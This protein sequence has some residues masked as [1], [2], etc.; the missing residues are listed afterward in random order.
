MK[1][2]YLMTLL[3]VVAVHGSALSAPL[4]AADFLRQRYCSDS[5]GGC[6]QAAVS[7]VLDQAD[8]IPIYLADP[9]GSIPDCPQGFQK[10]MLKCK[11]GF[12][13][14]EPVKGGASAE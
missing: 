6:C 8:S 4:S 10:N 5:A 2:F 3:L 7:R 1:R 14:C 12:A 9:E 11:G 13:W